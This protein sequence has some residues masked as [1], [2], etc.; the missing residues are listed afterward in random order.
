MLAAIRLALN[1]ASRLHRWSFRMAGLFEAALLV[2]S[3]VLGTILFVGLCLGLGLRLP[4]TTFALELFLT[5]TLMGAIRFGPRLY[6]ALRVRSPR[7]SAGQRTVI[8]GAGCAGD[9][10]LRDIRRSADSPYNIVGFLDDDPAKLGLSINGR[11]VLGSIEELPELVRKYQVTTALIAIPS[12]PA[13]RLRSI[14]KLCANLALNLK[15]LPFSIQHLGQRLSV[16]MLNDIEPEDL[17]P[18][19]QVPFDPA[20]LRIH[21]EGRRVLVTGAAGSI[22][23]EIVRQVAAHAPESL[24][25]VDL[26]ENELYLLV[27]ELEARHPKLRMHALVA[28]VRDEA[29]IMRIGLEHRPHSVFHAAAHKHVPLMEDA[30]EEALKNNVLGTRNVARMADAVEAERFVL[31]S[32]DK[33]VR[34]SSVMG[35]SKR[36]AEVVIRAMTPTSKTHFAAVRF[37]NVLGSAGS[38]IPLFKQQILRG[39]PVTV[40]HEDCTRYF[41]TIKEAVGLVLAAGFGRYGELCILEMGAPVRIVELASNMITLAGLVP[42]RDIP[43]VFTG[44]RPGEKLN[45]ELMFEG[46]EVPRPARPGIMV[47][48]A[49]PPPPATLKLIDRMEAALEAGDTEAAMA[50]LSELVPSYQPNPALEGGRPAKVSRFPVRVEAEP[51]EVSV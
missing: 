19:G 16:A 7:S 45:E 15:I 2:G 34:P 51:V 24:V 37:G 3:A 27:R 18:R 8:V 25:L 23:S 33:A 49:P 21:V 43:I 20:E 11:T 26:N 22:G 36:A 32:T 5:A 40:T 4:Y 35:A 9:L 12:L 13:G 14:L 50:Y 46:E 48:D 28:N 10:L 1:V 38:V 41:M 44:L 42:G 6:L 31:I 29:R 17:L 30:P 47:L 39:G